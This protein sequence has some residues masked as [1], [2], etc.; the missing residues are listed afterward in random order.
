[1]RGEY[2]ENAIREPFQYTEV[3]A[4]YEAAGPVEVAAAKARQ[5]A[6]GGNK[7]LPK[8]AV[9]DGDPEKKVR[10]KTTVDKIGKFAGVSRRTL[11]KIIA[12]MKTARP[13]RSY[14]PTIAA[15][16]QFRK[17]LMRLHLRLK[18]CQHCLQETLME[19]A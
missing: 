1:M 6:A 16:S 12:V 10:A 8:I 19:R 2:A 5:A 14:P 17:R 9:S 13:A 4:I 11:E 18:R 3:F 15:I 7:R